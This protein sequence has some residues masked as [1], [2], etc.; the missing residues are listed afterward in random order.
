MYSIL[1]EACTDTL[2]H[3]QDDIQEKHGQLH[4]RINDYFQQAHLTPTKPSK[5]TDPE[6]LI[7][8][9]LSKM[10]LEVS[11]K[12]LVKEHPTLSARSIAKIF[13]G[14]SSPKIQYSEWSRTKW[15]SMFAFYDFAD[16][17]RLADKAL[18]LKK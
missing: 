13:H 8:A 2:E 9:K 11:L 14:L 3:T 15:W 16:L 18:H 6:L 12:T 17:T 7:K 4:A 1:L 5:I 10:T